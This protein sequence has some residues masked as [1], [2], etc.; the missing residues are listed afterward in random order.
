MP[1]MTCEVL[2]VLVTL[3]AACGPVKRPLPEG[4]PCKWSK[5]LK[6]TVKPDATAHAAFLSLAVTLDKKDFALYGDTKRNVMS[7]R[8]FPLKQG[9]TLEGTAGCFSVPGEG[10]GDRTFML[11][12]DDP[13]P[14]ADVVTGDLPQ[15]VECELIETG[16]RA[17]DKQ[18]SAEL[19]SW[20]AKSEALHVELAPE[21]D[22]K[23]VR[24]G[25]DNIENIWNC[26]RTNGHPRLKVQ[27]MPVV[28]G[29]NYGETPGSLEIHPVYLIKLAERPTTACY[30][31]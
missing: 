25:P 24:I 2:L 18:K 17:A 9:I 8:L 20:R 27:G 4:D 21:N 13:T 30:G 15:A 10:D 1:R 28:D 19:R 16:D 22:G 23:T 5:I 12:L 11:S 31:F 29:V 26:L 3:T 14:L 7:A 6:S